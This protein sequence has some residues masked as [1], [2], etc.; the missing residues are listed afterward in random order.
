[1]RSR[2]QVNCLSLVR[3][4][5]HV[6]LTL[7]GA[8]VEDVEGV[9][10]LLSSLL[11]TEDQVDPLMEVI[12]HMLTFLEFNIQV[13]VVLN[14]RLNT[15]SLGFLTLLTSKIQALFKDFLGIV[16]RNLKVN[17]SS[18]L[19]DINATLFIL[20]A[21]SMNI[22]EHLLLRLLVYMCDIRL[23]SFNFKH[24]CNPKIILVNMKSFPKNPLFCLCRLTRAFLCFLMKSSLDVAHRGSRTSVTGSWDICKCPRS[25]PATFKQQCTR[26]KY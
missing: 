3:K 7:I 23:H 14:S 1:M 8:V 21:V 25:N 26:F 19:N 5:A 12:G 24:I 4:S 11:V 15:L 13:D 22:Y 20:P 2:R 6:F 10:C 17:T 9:H 18:H 16:T